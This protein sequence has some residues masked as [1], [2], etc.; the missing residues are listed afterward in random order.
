MIYSQVILIGLLCLWAMLEDI[1]RQKIPNKITLPFALAGLILQSASFGIAGAKDSLIGLLIGL[2]VFLLP[3]S[4]GGL[5]AGD[6]KLMAAIG[7]LSNWRFVLS[8]ALLT[9][10]AGGL[11]VIVIHHKRS[12]LTGL[13]RNVLA[14]LGY[15]PLW[16]ISQ[17]YPSP[18][19]AKQM[20]KW[21]V[22]PSLSQDNYI[23]YALP[24]G[25][26][27]AASFLLSYSGLMMLS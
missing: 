14:M 9:A 17:V 16:L 19:I 13:W 15:A 20:T 8:A 2:L 3:Y 11:I 1:T 18:R 26:G 4:L 27:V 12:T 24:V 23:P 22:E 21:R 6:V 25:L 7:A 5:G 10:L